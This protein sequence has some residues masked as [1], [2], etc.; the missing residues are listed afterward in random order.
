[1]SQKYRCKDCGCQFI[2]KHEKTHPGYLSDKA[3][4]VKIMLVREVGI[5]DISAI[6]K[7]SITK[8]LKVFTSGIYTVQPKKKCYDCLEIDE[9]W[10]YVGEKKNKI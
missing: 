7:T 1:V 3:G 6:L 4:L 9:L 5:R 2:S 8:V 10:T